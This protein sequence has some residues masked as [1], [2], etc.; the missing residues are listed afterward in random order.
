MRWLGDRSHRGHDR[1]PAICAALGIATLGIGFALCVL[2]V[3]LGAVVGAAVG[4]WLALSSGLA[5]AGSG[6]G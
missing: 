3:A 1:R 5:S 6:I 4:G 2:M